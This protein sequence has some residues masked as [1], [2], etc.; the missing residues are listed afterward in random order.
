MQQISHQWINVML[1]LCRFSPADELMKDRLS[2][3]CLSGLL[4]TKETMMQDL[5][6]PWYLS[7]VCTSTCGGVVRRPHPPIMPCMQ[8]HNIP[9]TN[10]D[11]YLICSLFPQCT[12]AGV[13]NTVNNTTLYARTYTST[14]TDTHTHINIPTLTLTL[15]LTTLTPSPH[16]SPSPHHMLLC[17]L[18]PGALWVS[19][20]VGGKE[21]PRRCHC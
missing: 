17:C 6:R 14:H 7:T 3:T 2:L 10:N 20:A 1:W 12:A 9:A 11:K 18:L 5:S 15:T 13:C 16:I 21:S 8:L 4:R 19:W